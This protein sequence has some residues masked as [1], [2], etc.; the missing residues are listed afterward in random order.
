MLSVSSHLHRHRKHLLAES[1]KIL[2]IRRRIKSRRVT[3][4]P[5]TPG[6]GRVRALWC[7]K[8]SWQAQRP[9]SALPDSTSSNYLA[10]ETRAG[11]AFESVFTTVVAS[12]AQNSHSSE[13]AGALTAASTAFASFA[14]SAAAV[15]FLG[16]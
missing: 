13:A 5:G 9:A 14:V 8:Q 12:F 10:A 7:A 2:G 15:F 1:P 11:A 6:E 3:P 4:S 16:A